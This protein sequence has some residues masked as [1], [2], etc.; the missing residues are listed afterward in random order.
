MKQSRSA[1][2]ACG[3]ATGDARGRIYAW[4]YRFLRNHHDALDATQEVMLRWLRTRSDVANRA[5]WLRRTTV[6]YC[7]DVLRRRRPSASMI[8]H[9]PATRASTSAAVQQGELLRAVAGGLEYLS[10]QQRQVLVAKIYDGA[11]FA[12]IADEL[13]LSIS[14]V[15]THYVRALGRM[16]DILAPFREQEK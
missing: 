1:T 9:E 2:D 11:T 12:A 14:T 16:R 7:I 15:K 13:D 3:I 4:A 5:A 10:D 6:N 8:D